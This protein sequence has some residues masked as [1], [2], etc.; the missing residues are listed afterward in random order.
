[1]RLVAIVALLAMVCLAGVVS[2]DE[3]SVIVSGTVESAITDFSVDAATITF[4]PLT[5]TQITKRL[6]DFP[7]PPTLSG[8]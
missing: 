4:D 7:A 1:M 2:A 3:D 5:T 6:V 8:K